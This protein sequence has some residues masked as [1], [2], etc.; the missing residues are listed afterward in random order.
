MT[1]RRTATAVVTVLVLGC[2]SAIG[3]RA[4]ALPSDKGPADAE[5]ARP[6]WQA[7]ADAPM[8]V[9]Q[10]TGELSLIRPGSINL[11]YGRDDE[12]KMDYEMVLPLVPDVKVIRRRDLSELRV[13][14]TVLVTYEERT[15]EDEA[16]VERM[17]RRATTIEF[18]R[19]AAA[20]MRS[21]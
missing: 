7:P 5:V 4:E 12:Q 13:G 14:D 8:T 1:Q 9:E 19:P 3:A 21:G 20:N 17:Q 2:F 15:W 18:L 10:V 6:R 16:E 11:V